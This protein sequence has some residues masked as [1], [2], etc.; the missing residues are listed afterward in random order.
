MLIDTHP[1]DSLQSE[2]GALQHSALWGQYL[3]VPASVGNYSY[4]EFYVAAGLSVSN[5]ISYLFVAPAAPMDIWVSVEPFSIGPGA[6]PMFNLASHSSA[7]DFG[8]RNSSAAAISAFTVARFPTVPTTGISIPCPIAGT[9]G[10]NTVVVW[11]GTVNT[12]FH[13]S[14]RVIS[15]V[16]PYL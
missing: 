8:W 6:N 5:L 2:L 15:S 9:V 4:A 11:G 16:A 12:A 3:S 13:L 1:S 7:S 14:S 10:I